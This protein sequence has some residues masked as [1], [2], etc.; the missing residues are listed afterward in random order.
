MGRAYKDNEGVVWIEETAGNRWPCDEP[1]PLKDKA[2][3]PVYILVDRADDDHR[4]N[5]WP[6]RARHLAQP[7]V[8]ILVDRAD[9]DPLEG[10]G[11][12]AWAAGAVGLAGC[13]F[14]AWVVYGWL[15]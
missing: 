12:V 9:D 13:A 7:P 10:R 2:Q 5:S 6:M 4:R 14:A 15:R 8:Y 3:E 11:V 1:R